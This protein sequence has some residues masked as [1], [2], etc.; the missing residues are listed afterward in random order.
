MGSDLQ[1]IPKINSTGYSLN[2][3]QQENVNT[4]NLHD[5]Q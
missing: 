4:A 5:M 3:K 2:K 1:W